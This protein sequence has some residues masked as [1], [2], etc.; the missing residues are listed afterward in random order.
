M[1]LTLKEIEELIITAKE[2]EMVEIIYKDLRLKFKPKYKVNSLPIQL[3]GAEALI[4][5]SEHNQARKQDS[6]VPVTKA[7]DLI[8]SL[9]PLDDLTAEEI[10]YYAV[11]HYDQ[12]QAEKEAHKKKLEEEVLGT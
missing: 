3:D 6:S 4:E 9:N 8:K 12:I 2:N 7:E 10:L 11:P 5:T 1:N